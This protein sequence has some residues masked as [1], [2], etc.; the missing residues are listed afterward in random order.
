LGKNY[1]FFT[2][3]LFSKFSNIGRSFHLGSSIPM[4]NDKKIKSN[5]QNDL[6]TKKNGEISKFK[7]VF[8]V[9]S[10]NFTNIPAGDVSL[11]IMA[12]ALRIA[13]ANLND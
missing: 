2:I 6:Y 10:S 4:L 9:D 7:N 8:I 5:T 13:E 3:K 12:N 11:T 1:G